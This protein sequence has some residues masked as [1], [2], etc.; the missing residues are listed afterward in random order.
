MESE[1][2]ISEPIG[3]TQEADSPIT[4]QAE[5]DEAQGSPTCNY[6]GKVYNV[7]DVICISHITHVCTGFGWKNLGGHC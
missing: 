3:T 7:G 6:D 2:N 4:E 5:S 1:S